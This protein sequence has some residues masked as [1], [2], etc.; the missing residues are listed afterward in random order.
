VAPR[1]INDPRLPDV[2]QLARKLLSRSSN[3]LEA[4]AQKPAQAIA[5]F[6]RF[7]NNS[8]GVKLLPD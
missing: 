4:G 8:S 5:S 7:R 3:V 6:S 1:G 2:E